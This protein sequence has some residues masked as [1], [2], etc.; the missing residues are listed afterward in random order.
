MIAAA[1]TV[2]AGV[3]LGA[4]A[5]GAAARSAAIPFKGTAAIKPFDITKNCIAT[6][7]SSK[8]L[9]V[10]CVQLG[11]FAGMP[12]PA[13]TRFGWIW[14]VPVDANGFTTGP[15]TERG[16]LILNFGAPGL[17]YLS[18]A[19]KQAPVGKGT[20]TRVA[21]LSKGTWAITRGTAGFVGR[22]GTGSYTFK[23]ARAGSKTVFSV[24]QLK[25][26]GSIT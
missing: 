6:S 5:G 12:G 24:A 10:R 4:V 8:R 19:G 23:T 21:A 20:P 17:L 3:A 18:L 16:T 2:L 7:L 15:A 14:D 11:K 25:L 13:N 1:G 9:R 26:S 22:H